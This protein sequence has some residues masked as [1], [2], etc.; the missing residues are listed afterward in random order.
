MAKKRRITNSLKNK[1][2]GKIPH[3]TLLSAE[4]AINKWRN[5]KGEIMEI[6]KCEHC[7][8]YHIGH[9]IGTKKR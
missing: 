4:Y 3:E 8:K 1:C 5:T 7:K 2:L 6:Y 9:K